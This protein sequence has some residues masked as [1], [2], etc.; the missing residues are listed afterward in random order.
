MGLD[1]TKVNLKI[2]RHSSLMFGVLHDKFIIADQKRVAITGANVQEHYN[3]NIDS[4]HD[5]AVS[6]QGPIALSALKAYDRNWNRAS[7]WSVSLH[8]KKKTM[9]LTK[10][11]NIEDHSSAVVS[12]ETGGIPILALPQL[13]RETRFG[14]H[15]YESPQDQ[16]W[17]AAMRSAQKSIKVQSPNIN[18]LIFIREM[19]AAAARGV[20]IQLIT[21]KGFNDQ[22]IGGLIPEVLF[23][24]GGT[25]TK[26]IQNKIPK[27][28]MR[29][30][31]HMSEEEVIHA[32]QNIEI[33]LI[34][35]ISFKYSGMKFQLV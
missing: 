32:F 15:M 13:S 16:G 27:E 20:K 30:T 1:L 26:V 2:G 12:E 11:K 10:D 29:A 22:K 4:W 25:N 17:I 5:L 8:A 6:Y 31:D 23:G 9:I 34:S 14:R 7:R 35:P 3:F 33:L 19:V 21:S 18:G 24:T 28:L